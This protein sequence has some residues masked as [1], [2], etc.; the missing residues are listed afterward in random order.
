MTRGENILALGKDICLPAECEEAL[1]GLLCAAAEERWTGRLRTGVKPEDC[2][3]ALRCA[4][5]FTAAGKAFLQAMEE[6]GKAE[7]YA[8]SPLGFADDRRWR[9][10]TRM[11][12]DDGDRVAF[13][14]RSFRVRNARAVYLGGE[15]C[16]Y[17]AIL[18]AEGEA[19]E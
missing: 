9:C 2:E 6:A 10:V 12:V 17:E 19:A 7:P 11:A 14:G 18:T 16:H 4:C 13:Q 1:L 3:E 8:V 5:A 15:L